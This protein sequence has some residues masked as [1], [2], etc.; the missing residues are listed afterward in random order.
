MNTTTG[1][2]AP[3]GDSAILEF[4]GPRAAKIAGISYRQLDHW[5]TEGIVHPSM[6]QA[7]GSGSRRRYRYDDLVE[8]RIVK[9]LRESGVPLRKIRSIFDYIRKDLAEEVASARLVIEGANVVL[10]RSDAELIDMLQRGQ[11]VL[12]VLPLLSVKQEVD[13]AI[14]ELFPPTA[15][16]DPSAGGADT[17]EAQ[18][19][20]GRPAAAVGE[21]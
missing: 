3:A 1:D 12:N 4:T 18:T 16:E 11:G 19:H 14:F 13:A 5:D 7:E 17:G 6:S 8:L 20:S 2:T 15:A 9:R 21:G 10:V